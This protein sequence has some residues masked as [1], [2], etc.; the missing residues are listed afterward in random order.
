M[1]DAMAPK[2]VFVIVAGLANPRKHIPDVPTSDVRRFLPND[3][4]QARLSGS[5]VDNI[6]RQEGF[7][8][9]VMSAFWMAKGSCPCVVIGCTRGVHRSPVVAAAAAELLRIEG[10]DVRVMEVPMVTMAEYRVR[11]IND[12]IVWSQ[13]GSSEFTSV[14]PFNDVSLSD[15]VTTNENWEKLDQLRAQA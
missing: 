2:R 1:A 6:V 10:Y 13:G 8:A 14:S 7:F 9:A 4:A 11:I 5:L 3:P 15:L 12:G